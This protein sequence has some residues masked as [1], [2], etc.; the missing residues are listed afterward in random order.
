MKTGIMLGLLASSLFITSVSAAEM[1]DTMMMKKDAMMKTDTMMMKK[2]M[3]VT[4]LATKHGYSWAKDRKTLAM[5][6]GIKNYR[7]SVAQNTMIRKYLE[8]MGGHTMMKDDKTMKKDTMMI[9]DDTMMKKDDIMMKKESGM[10]ST[11]SASAVTTSLAAGKSVYLFFHATWCPG[12]RALDTTISGDITS[13]PAGSV[14]YKVDYDTNEA[15]RQQ[16][17]VTSQHTVVKLNSDGSSMKK[18]MGPKNVMDIV[19]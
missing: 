10:Y 5:K 9:K 19:K 13:I 1:T 8:T 17:G 7:G 16:Y 11:Y 3:T 2:S 18:I 12:C 14:I 6:A 15:L 4:Q